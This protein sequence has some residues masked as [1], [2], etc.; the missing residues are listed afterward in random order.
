MLIKLKEKKFWELT[1]KTVQAKLRSEITF[2]LL[3]KFLQ[4]VAK[5][6]QYDCG[7]NLK[8]SKNYPK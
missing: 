5:S 3:N 1:T 6:T 8:W 7:N 2:E 4:A